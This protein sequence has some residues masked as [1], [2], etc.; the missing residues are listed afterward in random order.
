MRKIVVSLG[1]WK[2]AVK[3]NTTFLFYVFRILDNVSRATNDA[4]AG[5]REFETPDLRRAMRLS[6]RHCGI[7]FLKT[8]TATPLVG[9]TFAQC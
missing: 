5:R 1:Y 3:S 6:C 8:S 9:G 4:F 2:N 7:Y